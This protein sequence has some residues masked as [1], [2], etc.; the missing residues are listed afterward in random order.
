MCST[1]RTPSPAPPPSSVSSAAACVFALETAWARRD[2][3][4]RLDISSR[5]PREESSEE[6]AEESAAARPK[7]SPTRASS[8][9]PSAPPRTRPPPPRGPPRARPSPR[10]SR[11]C[12]VFS[13]LFFRRCFARAAALPERR[14]GSEPDPNPDPTLKT[15]SVRPRRPRKTA[16]P[17]GSP[18]KPRR[19]RCSRFRSSACFRPGWRRRTRPRT[20]GS[21]RPC[22]RSRLSTPRATCVPSPPPPPRRRARRSPPRLRL[23]ERFSTRTGVGRRRDVIRDGARRGDRFIEEVVVRLR[24]R[25]PSFDDDDD[26]FLLRREESPFSTAS[27]AF[28]SR[29]PF[30]HRARGLLRRLASFLGASSAFA[31]ASAGF[32]RPAA[33]RS[34]PSRRPPLLGAAAVR[35]EPQA[36]DASEEKATFSPRNCV[37]KKSSASVPSRARTETASPRARTSPRARR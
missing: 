15:V 4:S 1:P 22:A 28:S 6:S 16:R 31:D 24:S 3:N 13:A 36:A 26:E 23:L 30:V 18:P 10:P 12:A 8:P 7:K 25:K 5:P 17:E 2:V 29:T 14:H 33:S 27:S 20:R 37:W 32:D 11:T 35:L 19:S 9:R 34:R 21:P